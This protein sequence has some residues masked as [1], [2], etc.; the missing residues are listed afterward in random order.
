MGGSGRG[1]LLGTYRYPAEFWADAVALVRSSGRPV[2]QVAKEFGVNHETLRSW[3]RTA[4]RA[5]RPEAVAESVKDAELARLRREV[6]ELKLE[7]EILRKAAAYFARETLLSRFS[8]VE[9]HHRAFG[10]KRLCR[11]LKVSRSGFYRWR[12]AA[13]ARAARQACDVRLAEQIAA[14]HAGSG[15]T[16][17]SPRVHAELRDQGQRVNRKRVERVMREHAIVGRRLR[18]RCRTTIPVPSAVPVPDLLKRDFSTGAAN[19]RWC[20]DVTYLPVAG[21]WMYLATVIDI[22]TRRLIGYSMA[23]HMRADLVI[24]ALNAA[25]TTRGGNVAGVIFNSDHGA[26]YTS[27]AFAQACAKVGVRQS[28]G[29]VGTSADNSLAEAFFASLKREILPAGGWPTARQ[30]RLEVFG[31]LTFYNTRRRHSAL[32]HLSPIEYEHRASMLAAA[33]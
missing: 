24:D 7:R 8:F 9:A 16:Y 11:I 23:E 31:W 22:G 19:A 15:A 29:A 13:P 30:A 32:G 18:R 28:M 26:Q 1:V 2:A 4:E 25:V 5:E 33:A 3:V 6:A 10:V 17:G 14:I 27:Q 21:R 12:Q 20:G